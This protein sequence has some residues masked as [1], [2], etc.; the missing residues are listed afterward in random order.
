[1]YTLSNYIGNAVKVAKNEPFTY[2]GRRWQAALFD[3]DKRKRL[4]KMSRQVGKSTGGASEALVRCAK[5]PNFR[6]LYV[7]PVRDQ[8]YKFHNDRVEPILKNSPI[9]HSQLGGI[10]NKTEKAFKRG[11]KYYLVWAKHNPDNTRGVTSDFVHYDE[12]QDQ[13]LD[14]I[15]P[16]VNESRFTSNYDLTLYSGTPK[17]KANVIEEKW[18]ASD[19]REWVVPCDAHTPKVW[20]RLGIRNLGQKGPVCRECGQLLDVDQGRWVK[21]SDGDIAGFHVHQM[22]TKISHMSRNND[23]SWEW[24]QPSWDA[25]LDKFE[26][27]PRPVFK[28]EVLGESAD[29]SESPITRALMTRLCR[30]DIKIHQKAKAKHRRHKT[31]AGIDWGH[32][33]AATVIAIGQMREGV[34]QYVFFEPF[35]G[36]EC[37]LDY[38]IPELTN[39]IRAYDPDH[40]HADHGAGYTFNQEMYDRFGDT[41]STNI[42]SASAKASDQSWRQKKVEIPRLTMNKPQTLGKYIQKMTREEIRFPRHEDMFP[43]IFS[44]FHNVRKEINEK[45]SGDTRVRYTHEGHDDAFHAAVYAWVAGTQ[46]KQELLD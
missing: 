44:D 18:Q 9:I 36:K 22:H 10:N 32:G 37:Q 2:A 13:D 5:I 1:M 26:Q 11:G 42:W 23:G 34:F 12:I 41:F 30:P 21:H 28:N 24:H 20:Q 29:T 43:R 15:E 19:M 39:I 25:I 3:T 40:I 16:V 4:W 17:S 6:T 38:V 31:Y 33:E 35:E 45:P 8:V 7:A 14:S 27:Y 46:I